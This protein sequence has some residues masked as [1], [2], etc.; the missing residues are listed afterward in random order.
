MTTAN[1]CSHL[2]LGMP[3]VDWVGEWREGGIVKE[4]AR[5]K[6]NKKCHPK[7]HSKRWDGKPDFQQRRNAEMVYL[8]NLHAPRLHLATRK[9]KLASEIP[10]GL[11]ANNLLNGRLLGKSGQSGKWP[12]FFWCLSG[13][14][15]PSRG[16]RFKRLKKEPQRL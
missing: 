11:W 8:P 9:K 5:G 6:L 4:G 1:F 13:F 3:P 12:H 7:I 2:F 15:S 14:I 10:A 16:P